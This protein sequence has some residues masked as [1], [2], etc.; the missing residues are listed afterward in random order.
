MV[1]VFSM[2]A[3][4]AFAALTVSAAP[5][6]PQGA[7]MLPVPPAAEG[8]APNAIIAAA[9]CWSKCVR[10]GTTACGPRP[11]GKTQCCSGCCRGDCW[12]EWY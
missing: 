2:V 5:A 4:L 3:A 9:P 1:N 11:A 7:D 10:G 6:I 12:A 8:A